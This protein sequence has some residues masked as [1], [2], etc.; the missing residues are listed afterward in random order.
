MIF[1]SFIL[2]C[3]SILSVWHGIHKQFQWHWKYIRNEWQ[4]NGAREEKIRGWNCPFAWWK[5]TIKSNTHKKWHQLCKRTNFIQEQRI[6]VVELCLC[7]FFSWKSEWMLR[8]VK[9]NNIVNKMN[10][11]RA[12]V[13]HTKSECQFVCERACVRVCNSQNPYKIIYV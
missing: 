4:P 6:F 13:R 12:H 2:F 8:A 10:G 1:F 9:S 7:F 5:W 11:K 3:I